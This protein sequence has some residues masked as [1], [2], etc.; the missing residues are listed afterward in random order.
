MNKFNLLEKYF[1]LFL[2]FHIHGDQCAR[3]HTYF[4]FI[5]FSTCPYHPLS[6]ITDNKHDCCSQSIT[7]FDILQLNNRDN[8]CQQRQH[9][10]QTQNYRSEI[11]ENIDRIELVKHHPSLRSSPINTNRTNIMVNKIIEQ[12]IYGSTNNS[13]IKKLSMRAQWTPLLDAYPCGADVRFAWDATKSTRWNQDIQRE[14]EHRRFDEMFRYVLSIQQNNKI[15][16]NNN[17]TLKETNS[18]PLVPPGG[19]YCRIENDWRTR[20]NSSINN[21]SNTN[22]NRQRITL[23]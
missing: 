2:R 7:T 16:N 5:D 12:S 11:Y 6:S 23:K 22:K 20:Q 14:D 9:I 17:R 19:I 8:A 18:S 15:N 1:D 4:R 13:D 10:C 3:C 21:N